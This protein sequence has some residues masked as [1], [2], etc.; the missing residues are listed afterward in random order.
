MTGSLTSPKF[1]SRKLSTPHNSYRGWC[2]PLKKTRASP[3]QHFCL[4]KCNL[5]AVCHR[6]Y[7][8]PN[9]R[10]ILRHGLWTP[11]LI[12]WWNPVMCFQ[13]CPLMLALT[14]TNY[15][16]R[17]GVTLMFYSFRA[18]MVHQP[19]WNG[20]VTNSMEKI[21]DF[22]RIH[23]VLWTRSVSSTHTKWTRTILC[24]IVSVLCTV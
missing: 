11:S 17:L 10:Q 22:V 21:D 13:K 14:K 24:C 8:S 4:Y 18:E 19:F 7:P 23:Q 15:I 16:L 1:E 5:W 2:H 6:M 20:A 3:N 12:V 9:S